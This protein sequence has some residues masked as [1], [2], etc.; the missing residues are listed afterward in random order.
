MAHNHAEPNRTCQDGGI[1]L[2]SGE[3]AETYDSLALPGDTYPLTPTDK[4]GTFSALY[5]LESESGTSYAVK[6]PIRH[7]D[8]RVLLAERDALVRLSKHG[9]NGVPKPIAWGRARFYDS[10]STVVSDGSQALVQELYA[11]DRFITIKALLDSGD[12]GKVTECFKRCDGSIMGPSERVAVLG[13]HT[14]RIIKA[15]HDAGVVHRDLSDGNIL[16]DSD[17]ADAAHPSTRVIDFGQ[18]KFLRGHLTDTQVMT[19]AAK[20]TDPFMSPEM[21][22]YPDV[23]HLREGRWTDLFSLGALLWYMRLSISYG[24]AK[25]YER[26][27][28]SSRNRERI[29]LYDLMGDLRVLDEERGGT[30]TATQADLR[31]ASLIQRLTNYQPKYRGSDD[32]ALSQLE[33]IITVASDYDPS[34]QL[35][36]DQLAQITEASDTSFDELARRAIS[37]PAIPVEGTDSPDLEIP[38]RLYSLNPEHD[39]NV[40][41]PLCSIGTR[42]YNVNPCRADLSSGTT[43]AGL[44]VLANDSEQEMFAATLG[45][46]D[47]VAS[48]YWDCQSDVEAPW[49]KYSAFIESVSAPIM[50]RGEGGDDSP[51]LRPVTMAGWFSGLHS[52]KSVQLAGIDT[53][54]VTDMSHLFHG[55]SSLIAVALP[56]TW[57]MACVQSMEYMFAGCTSLESMS[58]FYQPFENLGIVP[59]PNQERP[60]HYLPRVDATLS[61]MNE[62]QGEW[63]QFFHGQHE[64]IDTGNVENFT[65]MFDGCVKL[66]LGEFAMSDPDGL[67]RPKS[68]SPL[69]VCRLRTDR[70]RFLDGFFRSCESLACIDLTAMST[71]QVTGMSSMFEGCTSLVELV[72]NFDLTSIR[73]ADSMFRN[74]SSIESVVFKDKSDAPT[75][76]EAGPRGTV[77]SAAVRVHASSMF[78]GCSSLKEIDL[79]L[80]RE[81]PIVDCWHMFS[82]CQSLE[83]L[84]LTGLKTLAVHDMGGM[85]LNDRMLTDIEGLSD[86]NTE[87]VTSLGSTFKGC[88]SLKNLDLH[89]WSTSNLK[90]IGR[91]CY[92]CESLSR[93]DLR[94]WDLS[95]LVQ[96]SHAFDM[97]MDNLRIIGWEDLRAPRLNHISQYESMVPRRWLFEAS[98]TDTQ[99]Y[100]EEIV[101]E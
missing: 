59:I 87:S 4:H 69:S 18:A 77:E 3:R 40:L 37:V 66:G 61:T 65:G 99:I 97:C 86:L 11:L 62:S 38:W 79:G 22:G 39:G 15:S 30:F 45:L 56:E 67:T 25:A 26:F 35:S 51:K 48:G 88:S 98:N 46:G 57:D 60:S 50:E 83:R 70:A 20:G 47:P 64:L 72:H 49:R 9:V 91:M 95:S 36:N 43:E 94:G 71:S 81:H 44:L 63:W 73:W 78:A 89:K 93:I 7:S 54:Y 55:C 42:T 33:G 6:V 53:S 58:W 74:A 24:S 21:H 85:F 10:T 23:I 80:L 76:D 101:D 68:K 14:M 52:L 92:G 2:R 34:L 31:L 17:A 28:I 96:A 27:L 1:F 29:A 19:I 16:F 82:D 75:Y 84:D 100:S 13:L 41:Y 12:L 8:E 5:T 32:D 90:T